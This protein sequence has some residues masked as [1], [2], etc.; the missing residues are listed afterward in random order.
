MDEVLYKAHRDLGTK[1]S[2]VM[3]Q[4]SCALA[5]ERL[6]PG[7]ADGVTITRDLTYGPHERNLLDVFKSGEGSRKTVLL[8]V[9][10]G[11]F[12]SGDRTMLPGL[13]FYDNVGLWAARAGH[14]GVT[15]TYR[16]APTFGWPS[17]AQ[18]V[19]A[20]VAWLRTHVAA[21]GGD[22]GCIFV[23]G[24]SAG[25]VHVADYLAR[26]ESAAEAEAN[27]AG[28]ILL[29]CIYDIGTS[30]RNKLQQAYF[31]IDPE[32]WSACSALYGVIKTKVPLLCTVAEFD[33]PDFQVQALR[34]ADAWLAAHGAYPPLL[35]LTGHNHLSTILQLGAED[36]T[37]GPE[38]NLFIRAG[39]LRVKGAPDG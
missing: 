5:Q 23:I 3:V 8:F 6:A 15:M 36:D 24:Q 12:V 14:V 28:A 16:L 9:H 32:G 2:P 30:E 13:P 10:G 18:D 20:A 11:G 35:R 38:L 33:I 34:F 21:Y 37:L 27:L 26:P 17:G 31:G 22:P 19:G 25:A 29:S 4:A 39:V 7:L 1:M